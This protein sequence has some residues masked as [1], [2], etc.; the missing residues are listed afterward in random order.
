MA[1]N[2]MLPGSNYDR[3]FVGRFITSRLEGANSGYIQCIYV[4]N[5]RINATVTLLCEKHQGCCKDGCCPKDQ[6]WMTGVY[7][8]LGFALFLFLIGT[9]TMLICY[10]RSK[11]LERREEK[12][13][14]TYYTYSGS[15]MGPYPDGYSTY[16]SPTT[17]YPRY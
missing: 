9:C 7:I 10:C 1:F 3:S 14:F 11:S 16:G 15:R 2:T 17:K 5:N 8:L 12:D 6:F 4:A 13:N